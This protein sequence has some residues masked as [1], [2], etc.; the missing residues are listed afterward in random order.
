MKNMRLDGP[1]KGFL[2]FYFNI[3][4]CQDK[5]TDLTIAYGGDVIKTSRSASPV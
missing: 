1:K 2:V 3:G 4:D 5:V